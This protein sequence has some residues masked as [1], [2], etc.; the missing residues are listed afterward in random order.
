MVNTPEEP[1]NEFGMM[2]SNLLEDALTESAESQVWQ[3]QYKVMYARCRSLIKEW[4]KSERD[5]CERHASL[6][7]KS[8]FFVAFNVVVIV[9][10]LLIDSRI[11]TCIPLAFLLAH[12]GINLYFAKVWR[13][14]VEDIKAIMGLLK[15]DGEKDGDE[16]QES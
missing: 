7:G 11:V 1:K 3:H 2:M 16:N 6:L 12:A 4:N 5:H 13:Q 8:A 15:E 9:L 14:K 10:G